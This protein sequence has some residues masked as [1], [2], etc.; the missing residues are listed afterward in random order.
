MRLALLL[1]LL[2]PL[3][4]DAQLSGTYTLGPSAGNDFASFEEAFDVLETDGVS[5]PVTIE[6]EAAT[7]TERQTLGVIRGTSATNRVTFLGLGAGIGRPLIRETP[8]STERWVIRLGKSSYVTFDNLQFEIA[9]QSQSRGTILLLEGDDLVVQNCTFRSIDD[10]SVSTSDAVSIDVHGDR[11]VVQDVEIDQGDIGIRYGAHWSGSTASGGAILR[12]DIDLARSAGIVAEGQGVT[13]GNAISIRDNDVRQNAVD[14]PGW[15]GIWVRDHTGGAVL[16]RNRAIPRSGTGV[17]IQNATVASP[18][19]VSVVNTMIPGDLFGQQPASGIEILNT[20]RARVLNNT[21]KINER[22]NALNDGTALHVDAASTGILV[23]NNILIHEDEG[24]L[25]DIESAASV[26][27]LN[28]QVFQAQQEPTKFRARL[29]G[30]THTDLTAYQAAGGGSASIVWPVTFFTSSDL[31]LA[32][33]SDG[34]GRLIGQPLGSAVP[35]DFDGDARDATRPYRG[36]DEA[37]TPLA[38]PPP[39]MSGTYT[40]GPGEDYASFTDAL[41]DLDARGVNAPVTFIVTGS[42][43][44]ENLDV[45][46]VPGSSLLNPIVFEGQTG[47][48]QIKHDAFGFFDDFVLRLTD[49][50]HM[51]FRRLAFRSQDATYANVA[52]VY[53][54]GHVTFDQCVFLADTPNPN[55]TLLKVGGNLTT[56]TGNAEAV[57]ILNSTFTGGRNGIDLFAIIS[58]LFGKTGGHE[59][60]GN[61]VSGLIASPFGYGISLGGTTSGLVLDNRVE[62][63]GSVSGFGGIRLGSGSADE[64]LGDVRVERNVVVADDGVGIRWERYELFGAPPGTV[65][66]LANNMVRMNG[67]G[68]TVGIEIVNATDV[69]FAHNTASVASRDPASAAATVLHSISGR[70]L[71]LRNNILDAHIGRALDLQINFS[72]Q[73]FDGNALWT[74]GAVLAHYEL[75]SRPPVDCADIACVRDASASTTSSGN[76]DLTSV[77]REV[78]FVDGPAG[79]LHLSGASVGDL[80][81]GVTHLTPEVADD[82]DG[83]ARPVARPYRGADE[84]ATTVSFVELLPRVYLQGAHASGN[85]DGSPNGMR[86]DLRTMGLLPLTQ[87][88]ADRRF[89]GT[90]MDYDGSESVLQSVLDTQQ[91]VDWVVVGLRNRTS[92]RADVYRRAGLLMWDGSVRDLDGVSVLRMPSVPAGDYYVA[93]Y[94]RNHLPVMSATT[95]ALSDASTLVRIYRDDEIYGGASGVAL[96]EQNA[97]GSLRLYGMVAGDGTAD[98]TVLADDDATVWKPDVGRGGYLQADYSLDGSVLADD[99]Q[100]LWVPNVGTQSEVP[101]VSGFTKRAS[102]E[103]DAALPVRSRLLD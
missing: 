40:I 52:V 17:R 49:V 46:P 96:L 54:G 48:P 43:F 65:L 50:E 102:R 71:D 8:T 29:G 16:A 10:G 7:Y 77:H 36:A 42:L 92:D 93:V 91:V 41:A 73:V 97:S 45:V 22:P 99:Q 33:R 4:A 74:D 89:D 67:N 23:Q 80:D 15:V 85:V 55:G 70:Y 88:Y 28:H 9:N 98:G 2:T 78:T 95:F 53:G 21:V 69:L 63:P 31:H 61:T 64:P 26:P 94:H 66:R 51:T 24:L 62:V 27:T 103:E 32:G 3:A 68:P 38:A 76:Q 87:P 37:A 83:D 44:F 81:L 35:S 5:G 34:D 56:S 30:I 75:G 47:T 14:E 86:T 13:S 25:L 58:G 100:A 101:G 20:D 11:V 1:L 12:T 60:I 84:A 59:V 6:V 19:W 82:L 79:D 18:M 39:Y 72:G 57:R 90:A